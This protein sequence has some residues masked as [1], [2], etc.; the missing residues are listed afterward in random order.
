MRLV[1]QIHKIIHGC[2]G[3]TSDASDVDA[4]SAGAQ[5]TAEAAVESGQDVEP[6]SAARTS[7]LGIPRVEPPE[8]DMQP[9]TESTVGYIPMA[10]PK[11]FPHGTG[12]YHRE[13][14]SLL[15]GKP[16]F[17]QWGRYML[18]WHDKRFS[19]HPRF[20]YWFL[21][22][23]LRMKT[24][25][26]KDVFLRV[27]PEVKDVTLE[28]LDSA[29]VRRK[30]VQ[31]MA[32]ATQTVPGSIG[33]RRRMRAELESMVEQK[34]DETAE[35]GEN[36]GKGRLPAV[37][38]TLTASVYTWEQLHRMMLSTYSLD[39]QKVMCAWSEVENV[40]ER[41]RAK[42]EAYYKLAVRN[43]AMVAWYCALKLEQGHALMRATISSQMR[44]E[45]VPGLAQ[46]KE[47]LQS[48][49]SEE[50]M[51]FE[52][53]GLADYIDA[54]GVC[55]DE[56]CA[57]EWS[58][59]GMIHTH[60]AKWI[61]GSP[62]LE[63]KEQ[64]AAS[65]NSGSEEE[66]LLAYVDAEQAARINCFYQR[67]YCEWNLCKTAQEDVEATGRRCKMSKQEQRSTCCPDSVSAKTLLFL[68]KEDLDEESVVTVMEELKAI[69][70]IDDPGGMDHNE[71]LLLFLGC[72][73]E[74]QQMHDYHTELSA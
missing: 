15:Q 3:P 2:T 44:S 6:L 45:S 37:F 9:I 39:D 30:V 28:E 42:K 31:Q 8:V 20:R 74:W 47:D 4:S 26:C 72:L 46:W 48:A 21:D 5:D 10:F 16:S 40:K 67:L 18:L 61:V 36:G 33:E 14:A 27:N 68:L 32:T 59:G 1:S 25:V 24:P 65:V 34:E 58:S 64:D 57:F 63:L 11:L 17:E 41:E 23:C 13:R 43:P 66:D 54:V 35:L 22:T 19:E 50:G 52:V 7:R 56:W 53:G 70:G 60:S 55:D 69:L 51:T 62:R 38:A 73:A 49:L 12:D 71:L 29:S